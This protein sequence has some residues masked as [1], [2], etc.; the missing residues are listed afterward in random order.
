[1]AV[2]RVD[3]ARRW[4]RQPRFKTASRFLRKAWWQLTSA[5]SAA[6]TSQAPT[7]LP[8]SAP[9]FRALPCRTPQRFL[10]HQVLAHQAPRLERHKLPL[11]ALAM[12]LS[13]RRRPRLGSVKAG[14]PRLASRA[15]VCLLRA[16]LSGVNRADAQS[17]RTRFRDRVPRLRAEVEAAGAAVDFR[18][19]V[20]VAT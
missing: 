5:R 17:N 9:C 18:A 20:A 15:G 11:P 7:S 14:A 10:A 4:S 16:A 8:L 1:M 3:R 13:A 12:F 2:L 19:A 6:I